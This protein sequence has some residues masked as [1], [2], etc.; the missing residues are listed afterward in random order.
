[1]RYKSVTPKRF[2][3][4]L[5]RRVEEWSASGGKQ[6]QGDVVPPV[7]HEYFLWMLGSL[8]QLH[9]TLVTLQHAAETL[10]FDVESRRVS[11]NTLALND[12]FVL[13]FASECG[14]GAFAAIEA[15][16][17]CQRRSRWGRRIY[18]VWRST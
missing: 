16:C 4:A 11:A 7:S 10:G 15:A 1:M 14:S 6:S 9:H 5:F 3:F 18:S 13:V 2:S 8:C 12:L 17:P